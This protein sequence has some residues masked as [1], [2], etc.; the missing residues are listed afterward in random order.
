MHIWFPKSTRLASTEQIFGSPMYS[1]LMIDQSLVLNRRRDG[2]YELS[3]EDLM[4]DVQDVK[5]E[6]LAAN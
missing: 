4:E 2:E 3:F 6:R 1:S 5:M